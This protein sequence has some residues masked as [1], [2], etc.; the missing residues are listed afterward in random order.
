MSHRSDLRDLHIVFGSGGMPAVI[1][2]IGSVLAL[3][4]AEIDTF[5]SIGGA[6][7]GT[8]PATILAAKLPPGQYLPTI[9]NQDFSRLIEGKRGF[10]STLLAILKKYREGVSKRPARGIWSIHGLQLT[11]DD[12]ISEWP[13][14]LW[15]LTACDDGQLLLTADGS[16]RYG[17]LYAGERASH[18]PSVGTAVHASCAVP[19]LVHAVFHLGEK[20]VDGAF[21]DDGDVPVDVVWRHFSGDNDRLVLAVDVGDDPIKKNILLRAAWSTFGAQSLAMLRQRP[22]ARPGLAFIDPRTEG[23]HSLNLSL[24][25]ATRWRAILT[26]FMSTAETLQA[27]RLASPDGSRK[28][29]EFCR[30]FSRIQGSSRN[31]ITLVQTVEQ[32]LRNRGLYV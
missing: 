23:F 22:A 15:I 13:D 4:V 24:S 18:T 19:G 26:G 31:S 14:N 21:T 32:F 29:I 1:A 5:S 28:L 17:G 11:I 9:I 27:H 16:F 12:M 8:I 30:E 10:L 20:L 7:G 6:S 25:S 2:G 3:N